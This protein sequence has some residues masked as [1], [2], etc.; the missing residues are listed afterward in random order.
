LQSPTETS[1]DHKKNDDDDVSLHSVSTIISVVPVHEIPR[2]TDDDK[3]RG[4]SKIQLFVIDYL[5]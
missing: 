2:K 5:A 1:A 3:V 4:S